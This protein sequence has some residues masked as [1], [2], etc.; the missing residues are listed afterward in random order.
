MTDVQQRNPRE[1]RTYVL[2]GYC[3]NG[4]LL[5]PENV[6]EAFERG[7]TRYRCAECA[8]IAKNK[9]LGRSGGRKR[10]RKVTKDGVWCARCGERRPRSEFFWYNDNTTKTVRPELY[11]KEHQKKLESEYRR[12]RRLTRD[13][14]KKWIVNTVR[15]KIALARSRGY[16]LADIAAPFGVTAHAVQS[17]QKDNAPGNL[18]NAIRVALYHPMFAEDP[19]EAA[20]EEPDHSS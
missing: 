12:R 5:S 9:R 19:P 8:L 18:R 2:G 13:A 7:R 14:D 1:R 3:K 20:D 17:W 11:C 10:P 6:W 16:R 4:H 15:R